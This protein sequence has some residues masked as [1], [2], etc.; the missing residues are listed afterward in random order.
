MIIRHK[1]KNQM[2]APLS[3]MSTLYNLHPLLH[4][5]EINSMAIIIILTTVDSIGQETKA[6]PSDQ[7]MAEW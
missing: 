7:Q 2:V 4:K 5:R 1:K 6:H 3:D